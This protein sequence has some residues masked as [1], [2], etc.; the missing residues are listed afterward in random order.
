VKADSGILL[1]EYADV[2]ATKAVMDENT[3]GGAE[4]VVPVGVDTDSEE[5]VINEGQESLDD[6]GRREFPPDRTFLLKDGTSSRMF[7]QLQIQKAG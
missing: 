1:N 6:E 3:H 5:D 7:H 2:P 4:F